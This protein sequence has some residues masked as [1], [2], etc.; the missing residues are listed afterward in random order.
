[1]KYYKQLK[2]VAAFT[3]IE[4]VI[5]LVIATIAGLALFGATKYFRIVTKDNI[6]SVRAIRESAKGFEIMKRDINFGIVIVDP[7]DD[8]DL[9]TGKEEPSSH[10]PGDFSGPLLDGTTTEDNLVCIALPAVDKNFVIYGENPEDYVDY[11][12]F[13][14]DNTDSDNQKL[15]RMYYQCG[16]LASAPNGD[17]ANRFR[18][19][20]QVYTLAEHVTDLTFKTKDGTALGSATNL[21]NKTSLRISMTISLPGAMG[22]ISSKTF[23]TKITMRNY[24]DPTP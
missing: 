14:L 22:K 8:L 13:W 17:T 4:M 24:V 7:P 18:A 10:T 20:A 6:A 15:Q 5:S 23:E 21:D 3:L 12:Y 1:M 2:A 16:S 11:V 9:F 19:H